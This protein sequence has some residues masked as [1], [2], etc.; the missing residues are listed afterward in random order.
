[1]NFKKSVNTFFQIHELLQIN[2]H[3]FKF[4]KK[5]SKFINAF[6][7]MNLSIYKTQR[8]FFFLFL[9]KHVFFSF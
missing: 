8:S 4:A 1:M 2:K 9:D 6:K 7:C 5:K 3:F